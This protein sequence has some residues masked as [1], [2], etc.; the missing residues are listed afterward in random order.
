MGVFRIAGVVMALWLTTGT[1]QA[2][3]TV[4][5]RQSD[6]GAREK[7]VIR[8]PNERREATV[9][10]EATFPPEV[11]VTPFEEKPG[12]R[13]EIRRNE[14]GAIVGAVWTGTLPPDH[15]TEFSVLATNPRGA[16]GLTWSF[17][18]TYA[19]GE[20]VDWSGPP[21]AAR[22]APRVELRPAGPAAA[23]HRH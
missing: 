8:T 9:R 21:G 1:A 2:H 23:A 5:P 17:R 18:Q 11:K 14:K 3:I 22:P 15:F 6:Q 19:G 16:A 10:I 13:L 4:W 20:V 7:Y 12:W